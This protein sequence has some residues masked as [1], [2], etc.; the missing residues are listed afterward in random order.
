MTTDHDMINIYTY[1][2]KEETSN[3]ECILKRDI[4]IIINVRLQNCFRTSFDAHDVER[5]ASSVYV[6]VS[7][8]MCDNIQFFFILQCTRFD[9]VNCFSVKMN[10]FFVELLHF[11]IK[12]DD[13]RE[14][15]LISEVLFLFREIKS[16]SNLRLYLR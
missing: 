14:F 9:I 4:K 7:A 10:L 16:D 11:E 8:R 6:C 1:I 15:W 12:I 2:K 13:T 5:I 3:T